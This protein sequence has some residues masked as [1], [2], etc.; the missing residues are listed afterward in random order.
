[1]AITLRSR[2]EVELMKKAG[3]VVADVLLKLKE[4]AVAGISTA[5]LNRIA[6]D[7]TK[8]AGAIALFKGIQNPY[9]YKAFPAAIC[10]S[11]NEQVVH[12]IPSDKVILQEGDILS[13]DFGVKLLGYCGDAAVTLAI[14][15]ID[16]QKQRLMYVTARMLDTAIEHSRAGE[17]WSRVAGLMQKVAESAGFSVVTDFVGHGIGTQMH[18]DPKVPNYVSRELLH[19]DILL[20][21][22]MILAVEP[23][24]NMGASEVVTLKDGWTVAAKDGRPSAHF[25]HTIAITKNGCEVLTVK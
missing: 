24:V 15:A 25:E 10:T 3:G 9:G 17:K 20:Q 12:G 11:I 23:M 6:E 8:Q 22:G 5:E 13:V 1:M 21:E 19:N 2:R 18:E 16:E 7:V 4:S 14:G